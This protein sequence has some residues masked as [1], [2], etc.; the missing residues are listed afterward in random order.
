MTIQ[1]F[2]L[3]TGGAPGAMGSRV[4]D[5]PSITLFPPS[6]A[7]N[8]A[9][10]LVYPGG[11]YEA[12]MDYEGEAYARWLAG[13][14]YYGAVVNYRLTPAGYTLPLIIGD[15]MRAVRWMRSRAAEL[16][17]NPAKIGV[18]GSSA[19]GHLCANLAVRWDR[20]T[21]GSADVV[22]RVGSRPDLAVLCYP[23]IDI[24]VHEQPWVARFFGGK[25]PASDTAEYFSASR[26]VRK[27]TA[28]CFLFHTFEDD[29]VPDNHSLRMAQAL[30][31][32]SV[33]Y[34][35]HLYERGP[36]GLALGNHQR[37]G[38]GAHPW[39]AACLSWLKDR[40]GL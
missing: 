18:I 28:P 9:A 2:P 20:G 35:L 40:F 19:G 1:T 7:P 25:A 16:G 14:G 37:G 6:V 15:G 24:L 33:P 5:I 3:W 11:G 27:E 36:H 12:L 23:L 38:G 10:M 17:F 21:A 13:Q 29:T 4:E 39:T 8:G 32:N 34:E 22:E 31:E 26:H 30:S